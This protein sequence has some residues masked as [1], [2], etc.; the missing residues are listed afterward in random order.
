MKEE[1]PMKMWRRAVT[2]G[3][4]GLAAGG[5][6][7]CAEEREPINRTQPNSLSKSFFVGKDLVDTADDPSFYARQQIVDLGY[8][9]AQDGLFTSTYAAP[10]T[11]RQPR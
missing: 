6:S 7:G 1:K 11:V 2:I 5:A 9:A 8:G 4:L 10:P 3:A